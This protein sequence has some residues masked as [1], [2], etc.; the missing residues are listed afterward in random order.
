[1]KR[2]IYF[3]VMAAALSAAVESTAQN[4]D[5]TVVVDRAYEGK[6]MEVHKPYIDMAV[7]DSVLRFDLDFDYSVFETPYRRSYE[8]N[9]YLLSMRPDASKDRS[10]NL[11]LKAGAGYQLHPLLDFIWSPEVKNGFSVDVYARHD[12]F[13]GKYHETDPVASVDSPVWSGHDLLSE[14][15][16]SGRYDWKGGVVGVDLGYYGVVAK[17]KVWSRSYNALDA[18]F[19]LK[20]K[21]TRNKGFAYMVDAD[22]RFAHDAL[23]GIPMVNSLKE[24]VFSLDASFGPSFRGPHRLMFDIGAEVAGYSDAMWSGAG[25]FYLKPGYMYRKGRF[26]VDVGIRVAKIFDSDVDDMAYGA[27]DSEQI[28]YPDLK[29][30]YM[31]VPDLLKVYAA[32]EGGNRMNTY[33]SLLD[34]N[35]HLNPQIYEGMQSPLDYTV[36]KA[37]AYAGFE[38][39]ARSRF[40]YNVLAGYCS[41]A[42]APLDV[43]LMPEN[44]VLTPS[45][46]YAAYSKWYA[47]ADMR[48]KSES[49]EVNVSATY[50]G[51]RGEV[52]ETTDNFLK[53]SAFNAAVAFEY[54]WNRRVFAG[55]DCEFASARSSALYTV[56][57]YA[58]LGLDAEYAFN[59]KF[60]LWLRV[61]NILGMNVQR[62][63][64]YAEKG[65]YFSAGICLVL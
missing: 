48:W 8:F 16:V 25:Q 57:W 37:D 52:F 5:P 15:G 34:R 26:G 10:R 42:N 18:H 22:Y 61:G 39:S 58:D 59:R 4:L 51:A 9:P 31:L 46:G 40:T 47:S 56:P 28:V 64:L 49:V 32:V 21:V 7:P 43:V 6:L 33:A 14:A 2:I 63:P 55:L 36:V 27:V 29:V 12:S 41:Y 50:D 23:K 38:G 53:P 1:M 54:N 3:S 44:G 17:D 19:S 20:S 30:E 60:S 35:H 13:V 24:H 45:L 65:V 62:N 11:Y